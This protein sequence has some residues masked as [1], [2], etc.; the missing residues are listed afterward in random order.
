MCSSDLLNIKPV[1]LT[2]HRSRVLVVETLFRVPI[3]QQVPVDT[4]THVECD[5]PILATESFVEFIRVAHSNIG[6]SAFAS[7]PRRLWLRSSWIILS[8][9]V[10]NGWLYNRARLA[11]S[12]Q[13]RGRSGQ[14]ARH[15]WVYS[16]M[17]SPANTPTNEQ[18]RR[19]TSERN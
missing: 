13:A 17:Q 7:S 3:A 15:H 2:S 18:V 11:F 4:L 19:S 12:G 6:W 8:R 16:S 10:L 9:R 1:G 14:Y 5:V